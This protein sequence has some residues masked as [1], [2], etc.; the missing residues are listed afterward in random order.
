VVPH[1]P[2][3]YE[4]L[5]ALYP[6]TLLP[7]MHAAL[8][9]KQFGLQRVIQTAIRNGLMQSI[10]INEEHMPYFTNWNS[11]GDLAPSFPAPQK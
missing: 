4:P 6:R 7:G 3:G 10:T 5:V 2:H 8:A 1:G 9:E 11:P